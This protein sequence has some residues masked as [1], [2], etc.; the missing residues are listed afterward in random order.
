MGIEPTSVAWEA[1]ALPLSYARAAEVQS[2]RR[3]PPR[4]W[5]PP[6]SGAPIASIQQR[7][8]QKL[9]P[10]VANSVASLASFCAVV[11]LRPMLVLKRPSGTRAPSTT[12]A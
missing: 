1:T 4:Q 7:L 6:A 9:P 11:V 12:V 8:D 10:K 2:M 3:S 5:A